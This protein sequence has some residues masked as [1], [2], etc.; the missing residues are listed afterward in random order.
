MPESERASH[1]H[2]V[3][4]FAYSDFGAWAG[5]AEL[6]RDV[7]AWLNRDVLRIAGL[8]L[9]DDKAKRRLVV[10]AVAE[11]SVRLLYKVP[12]AGEDASK[13]LKYFQT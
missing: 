12:K 10:Q 6:T 9:E 11:G 7:E 4:R 8:E 1:V 3:L 2:H 5:N 13:V